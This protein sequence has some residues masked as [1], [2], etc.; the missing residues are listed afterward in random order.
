MSR[1]LFGVAK[2]LR[3][4]KSSR[5]PQ[6]SA[7]HANAPTSCFYAIPAKPLRTFAGIALRHFPGWRVTPSDRTHSALTAKLRLD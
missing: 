6:R 1:L 7:F 3:P 5:R 2:V 4:R